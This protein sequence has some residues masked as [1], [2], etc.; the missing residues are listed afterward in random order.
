MRLGLIRK[1]VDSV[2]H[3][4]CTGAFRSETI[5]LR[6]IFALVLF[7]RYYRCCWEGQE[8]EEPRPKAKSGLG[9]SDVPIR[10]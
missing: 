9:R 3:V 8:V 7:S 1:F 4:Q 2:C 10:Y 5:A 6:D